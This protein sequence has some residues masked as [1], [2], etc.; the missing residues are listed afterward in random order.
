ML[1]GLLWVVG[2]IVGIYGVLLGVCYW[3]ARCGN[4]NGQTP[5]PPE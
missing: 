1:R 5:E 4:G 3:L 2:L